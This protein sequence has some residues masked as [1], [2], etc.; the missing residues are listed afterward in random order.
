MTTGQCRGEE[1]MRWRTSVRPW[2]VLLSA[3]LWASS[4][5]IVHAGNNIWT[6]LGP[7][8]AFVNAL[9]IDPRTSTTLYAGTNGGVFKST[10]GGNTW[11]AVNTGLPALFVNALAIVPTTPT[12]LYAGTGISGGG[13][14]QR[15]DG[16]NTWSAVNTGLT[17]PYVDTL[18]IDPRTPTTLYAGTVDGGVLTSTDGGNT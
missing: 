2:L 4:A 3:L 8:D 1:T 16:G 9:A 11:S 18:A 15:T 7:G 12:T 17:T 10:D 14:F 6:S 13:V 5:S